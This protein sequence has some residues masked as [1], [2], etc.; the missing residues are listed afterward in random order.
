MRTLSYW[1]ICKC[2]WTPS[3]HDRR[4]NVPDFWLRLRDVRP[5]SLPYEGSEMTTS[6]NR[7]TPNVRRTVLYTTWFLTEITAKKLLPPYKRKRNQL[8]LLDINTISCNCINEKCS[9]PLLQTTAMRKNLCNCHS[10]TSNKTVLNPSVIY[11]SYNEVL[12]SIEINAIS[13][14]LGSPSTYLSYFALYSRSTNIE[15][16]S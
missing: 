1:N 9:C 7:Y 15:F 6:L 5:W 10:L 16:S 11:L 8:G 13:V 4:G 3:T 14:T 12:T 2:F